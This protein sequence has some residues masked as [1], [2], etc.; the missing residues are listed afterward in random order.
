MGLFELVALVCLVLGGWLVVRQPLAT[1]GLPKALEMGLGTLFIFVFLFY[2]FAFYLAPKMA[3]EDLLT[4][5]C[6]HQSLEMR[7]YN[8]TQDSCGSVWSAYRS[9]CEQEAKA[10]ITPERASA[11]LGPGIKQCTRKAYDHS[12][13]SMRRF[14]EDNDCKSLFAELDSP[15]VN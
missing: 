7:C 13:K 10:S 14:S 3:S 2:F 15:S 5:P 11:L 4:Q 6:N 8:I 9:Q 1:Y 12:L